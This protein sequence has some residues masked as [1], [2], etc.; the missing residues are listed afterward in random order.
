M[1]AL[2]YTK[3]KQM[4][5]VPQPLS[6]PLISDTPPV[7][8]HSTVKS[9]FLKQYFHLFPFSVISLT[10]VFNAYAEISNVSFHWYTVCFFTG[11]LEDAA[12]KLNWS[13]LLFS[14]SLSLSQ[15]CVKQS[16][17]L[18]KCGTISTV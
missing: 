14:H 18:I 11:S 7:K 5:F 17:G 3:K 15:G 1:N 8:F 4:Q 13:G 2:Q 9:Y 10:T 12:V 6:H 16:K